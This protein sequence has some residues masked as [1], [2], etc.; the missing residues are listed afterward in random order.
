MV[1][2]ARHGL[3]ALVVSASA[4]TPEARAPERDEGGQARSAAAPPTGGHASAWAEVTQ[5]PWPASPDGGNQRELQLAGACGGQDAALRRVAREIAERRGR[6][7]GPPDADT[8]TGLL[9]AAGEPHVRPRV[10]AAS[11]KAPLDDEKLRARL[12]DLHEAGGGLCGVA[13]G[14]APHGVEVLVAVVVETLA[15]LEP[16]PVR[17]RTGEWLTLDARLHVP[18]HSAKLVVLGPK[19]PP[20]TVPT[21]LDPR[22]GHARAHFTLDQPGSFLVQLLADLDDGPRPLLEA[23]LFADA[24][25][26][27]AVDVEPAPGEDAGGSAR[28]DDALARMLAALRDREGLVTLSRDGRLD[29]LARVHA[30]AMLARHTVAHDV[31]E[32]DVRARF[33][34]RNLSARA[35]GENVAHAP[36]V[37][38]AHR[39]LH[40]SPS[41]RLNLLNAEYTHVGV[42]VESADDGSVYACEVFAAGLR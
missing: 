24:E 41:H 5:S 12:V 13:I 39:A 27:A 26:P 40:A 6:G 2:H 21:S 3:V 38:L 9:R 28:G 15:D 42:A 16:L 17:A 37:Q 23:R 1:A 22:T 18:A 8:V 7:L 14:S 33:E 36:T 25:P 29:E 34:A 31:G 35:L 11:G 20:R 32:G 10:L 30:R 19:G 4:C